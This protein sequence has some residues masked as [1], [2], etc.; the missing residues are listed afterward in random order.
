MRARARTVR[1][2]GV[3]GACGYVLRDERLVRAGAT[4]AHPWTDLVVDGL[5]EVYATESAAQRLT[6]RLRLWQD[7]QGPIVVHAVPDGLG[8]LLL[9]R[10]EM[11]ATGR[12]G[13]PARRR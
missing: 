9:N 3:L 7:P 2:D 11:P 6:D 1:L 8:E 10:A 4:L 5:T 12:R 13:R